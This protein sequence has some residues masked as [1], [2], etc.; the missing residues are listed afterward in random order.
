[1]KLYVYNLRITQFTF[2]QESTFSIL[3][4]VLVLPIIMWIIFSTVLVWRLDNYFREQK[5]EHINE[6]GT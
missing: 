2:M 3:F 6:L 5:T 4:K 1:M